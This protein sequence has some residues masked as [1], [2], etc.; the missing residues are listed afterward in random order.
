V[1]VIEIALRHRRGSTASVRVR[2]EKRTP[3]GVPRSSEKSPPP[4]DHRRTPG[5][6]LLKSPRR[7]LFLMSEVPLFHSALHARV[8][9]NL[10]W[11]NTPARRS[12]GRCFVDF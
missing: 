9:G 4:Y 6:V 7:G 5:K 10:R 3:T 12:A 11:K 1:R 8:H 2:R